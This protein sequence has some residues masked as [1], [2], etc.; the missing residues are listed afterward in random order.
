[1]LLL[2]AS[3]PGCF[4]PELVVDGSEEDG[5]GGGD[6][7]ES[8]GANSGGESSSGGGGA[9]TGGN[10]SSGGNSG[11]GA[12]GAGGDGSGGDG[13]GGEPAVAKAY[14]E[15][16]SWHGRVSTFADSGVIE[17]ANFDGATDAPYCMNGTVEP[18]ADP[19]AGAGFSWYLNQETSCQ[20]SDCVPPIATTG[21]ALNGIALRLDNPGDSP[22]RVEVLGANGDDNPDDRWCVDLGQVGGVVFVPWSDFNTECWPGGT[23]SAYGSEPLERLTVVV[24]G[25]A[26]GDQDFDF[27][28]EIVG[29]STTPKGNCSTTD[30]PGLGGFSL[31][32][33]AA[34]EVLRNAQSYVVT[35][36]LW[37][38][39]SSQVIQGTGTSFAVT[40]AGQAAAGSF[41]TAFVG[42]IGGLDSGAPWLPREPFVFQLITTYFEWSG[43]LGPGD[44]ALYEMRFSATM[45]ASDPPSQIMQIWLDANGRT[46]GGSEALAFTD[47][48]MNIT[49]DVFATTQGGVDAAVFVAPAPIDVFRG[50]V[51]DFMNHAIVD[52]SVLGSTGYI[53][54]TAAGFQLSSGSGV[55]LRVEDFCS[56]QP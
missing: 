50:D 25:L 29:E 51:L 16:G 21:P 13:S 2:G 48:I 30:G 12:G 1:M 5:S 53:T 37:G 34:T 54:S 56:G 8:G 46:P 32:G 45:A 36:D 52:A 14:Y 31:A 39:S 18:S 10:A 7:D 17:P 38:S 41:P 23:G 44:V 27:C 3:A 11:T 20:G 24:P 35:G 43:E 6:S 55:G 22:L 9:D 40:T 33:E 19:S 15:S 4:L 47:P 26:E 49:W 28:V 42:E